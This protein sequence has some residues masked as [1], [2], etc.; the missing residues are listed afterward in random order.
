M[1]RLIGV[2]AAWVMSKH[3]T[4]LA[5]GE[6]VQGNLL[7]T[8]IEPALEGRSAVLK[9]IQSAGSVAGVA[10][11]GPLIIN[12]ATGKRPGERAVSKRYA[13]R[14]AAT[15]A[16][17]LGLYPDADTVWLSQ[18]LEALGFDH[19]GALGQPFQIECYPHAALIE[20]FSLP[21][22]L[23]YKRKRGF[24]VSDQRIGQS[25][26]ARKLCSLAA[27][28]TVSLEI[29]DCHR[30]WFDAARIGTLKGRA[31]KQN[32]DVLDAIVCLYISA[33]FA[34]SVPGILGSLSEGYIYVPG[35]VSQVAD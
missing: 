9:S 35:A 12:N 10:V 20:I 34:R 22:R 25:E 1:K 8:D 2:D 23:A 33:L 24:G 19:A 15:H 21:K 29:P 16:S 5:I 27:N 6:M 7:V 13:A 30:S 17:N 4:A 14:G 11:D 31:L 32:E 26:L 3:P 18:E 28:A